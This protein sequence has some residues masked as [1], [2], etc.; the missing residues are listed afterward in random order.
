MGCLKPPCEKWAECSGGSATSSL[1]VDSEISDGACFPNSTNL[2]GD[3]AKVHIV[4]NTDK[5]PMVSNQLLYSDLFNNTLYSTYTFASKCAC[6]MHSMDD[7]TT[8]TQLYNYYLGPESSVL[9]LLLN[10]ILHRELWSKNFVI[11]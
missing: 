8:P 4:F 7:L 10:L 1:Q 5:L 6:V 2:N 9:I 3:C 11:S